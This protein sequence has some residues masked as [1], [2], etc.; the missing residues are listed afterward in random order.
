MPNEDTI[1]Q[2]IKTLTCR[3]IAR[4]TLHPKDVDTAPGLRPSEANNLVN[5]VVRVILGL[6]SAT[7]T[8]ARTHAKFTPFA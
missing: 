6:S 7:T 8:Q 1:S 2:L 3:H 5:D 4:L